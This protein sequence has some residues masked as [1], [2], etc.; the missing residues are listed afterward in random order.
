MKPN[1][2]Q[3]SLRELGAGLGISHVAARKLVLRG[4]PR[5]AVEA[6]TE[7]R[8]HNTRTLSTLQRYQTRGERGTQRRLRPL[9]ATTQTFD[10]W[11]ERDGRVESIQDAVHF[12]CFYLAGFEQRLDALP[13]E[14]APAVRPDAPEEAEA[15]LF[16]WRETLRAEMIARLN[17][18]AASS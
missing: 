7:W 11:L 18:L 6:A 2:N 17:N 1:K 4:M 12:F 3:L 15:I 5:Y 13:A 10:D 14:L 9:D 8:K 16:A